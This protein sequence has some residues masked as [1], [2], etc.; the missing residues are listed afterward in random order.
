M[1]KPSIKIPFVVFRDGRPRFVPSPKMRREGKK[2]GDLRNADGSWMDE[3]Q[4]RD[5]SEDLQRKLT[6]KP[7]SKKNKVVEKITPIA[8]RFTVAD[9][10]REWLA[11]PEV[12]G[13]RPSTNRDYQQKA[14]VLEDFFLRVQAAAAG[15]PDRRTGEVPTIN[16]DDRAIAAIWPAEAAALNRPICTVL[17][18]RLYRQR[19]AHTANAVMTL[20]GVAIEYAQRKGTLPEALNPAHRLKKQ[21]PKTK[22]R[23]GNVEEIGALVAAADRLGRPEI[24]DMILLGVWSGQR[25]GDRLTLQL[26]NLKDGRIECRQSKTD[27]LVSIPIAPLLQA[28]LEAAM[29]RRKAAQRIHANLILDEACW[30]PFKADHYR[31]VYA[32]VRTE[33]MKSCPAVAR[34][35]DKDMRKTSVVWLAMAGCSN[36]EI[37]SITGHSLK[38]VNDILKHYWAANAQQADNA[39]EKLTAWLAKQQKE[40]DL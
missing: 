36:T 13:L 30:Q 9:L 3:R 39:I 26:L 29:A 28:R 34:L 10:F 31:H 20:L 15:Q 11:S 18:E 4:A 35:R 24:G 17:Y 8:G 1:K 12:L 5:W 40:K 22:V 37:A 7:T 14:R 33:A 38:T 2:G 6:R 21:M 32:Q 23:W 16:A 25:Q 27:A 19:G